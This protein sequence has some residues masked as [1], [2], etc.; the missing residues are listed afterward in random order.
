MASGINLRPLGAYPNSSACRSRINSS[1]LKCAEHM[2]EEEGFQLSARLHFRIHSFC[3]VEFFGNL[4]IKN[5]FIYKYL[6]YE[7]R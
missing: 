4:N 5:V 3:R 6:T 2:N 7:I 1:F